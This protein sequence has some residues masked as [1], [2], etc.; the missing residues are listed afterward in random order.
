MK[1]TSSTKTGYTAVG[2]KG[3]LGPIISGSGPMGAFVLRTPLKQRPEGEKIRT[4]RGK[5]MKSFCLFSSDSGCENSKPDI[6]E[7]F[8]ASWW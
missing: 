3:R 1:G 8:Q 6:R 5:I 2:P 4:S 7:V